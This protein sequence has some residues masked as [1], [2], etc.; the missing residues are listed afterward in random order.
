MLAGAGELEHPR[1]CCPARTQPGHPGTWA[2]G[3][4][5]RN[6]RAPLHRPEHRTRRGPA[7]P[8]RSGPVR[9]RDPPARS[10]A[11]GV[12]SQPPRARPPAR[13]RRVRG[14]RA[15]PGV[16]AVLT[17]ADLDFVQPQ[18]VTGP[19]GLKTPVVHPLATD[20]VRYVGDPVALVVAETPAVA[21]DGRDLV[22]VDAEPLPAVVRDGRRRSIP[23]RRPSSTSWVTTS[24]TGR[25]RCGA[26]SMTSSSGADLVVSR[27]LHP[28]PD[29][30]RP[31]RVAWR[32]GVVRT[33]HGP[34]RVRDRAQAAALDAHGD[35]ARCSAS[36][37]A[38]ST[39][40]PGDIGGAFGSKG[41]VR[42]RG[43]RRLARPRSCSAG[44]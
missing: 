26:R 31:A 16:V 1:P 22:V 3:R 10:A 36:R 28:A 27:Q 13:S 7:V 40:S 33:G 18:A 39:S 19:P 15:L 23:R 42:P 11:R 35:V 17:A 21:A 30:P 37:S 14:A 6:W 8:H 29:Q 4:W 43:R 44:R 20:K 2:A 32:R 5:C 34:A 24:C 41:Q 25:R 12:R 9:L 38:T